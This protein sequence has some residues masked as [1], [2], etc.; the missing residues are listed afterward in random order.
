MGGGFCCFAACPKHAWF[1]LYNSQGSHVPISPGVPYLSRRPCARVSY[2]RIGDLFLAARKGAEIP[3]TNSSQLKLDRWKTFSFLFG[4]RWGV[5]MAYYTGD[6]AVS[7][8]LGILF[9]TT[10]T[11][12]GGEYKTHTF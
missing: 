7:F 3:E 10:S 11:N 2:H 5:G 1:I 12:I 4:G 6:F 8:P 9:K